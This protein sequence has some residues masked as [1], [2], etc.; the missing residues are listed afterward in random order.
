M[1]PTVMVMSGA[2]AAAGAHVWDQG[3]AEASVSIDVQWLLIP[4]KAEST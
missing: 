4:V 1:P 2:W 3:L